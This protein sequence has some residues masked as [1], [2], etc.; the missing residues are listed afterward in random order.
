MNWDLSMTGTAIY[1]L[2]SDI[3]SQMLVR[4]FS[5]VPGEDAVTSD[6]LVYQL[7]LP[8]STTAEEFVAG[9]L[10]VNLVDTS[11]ELVSVCTEIETSDS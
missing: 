5:S 3:E 4:K 9:H 1:V 6:Q 2:H 8:T 10:S 7:E 11:T